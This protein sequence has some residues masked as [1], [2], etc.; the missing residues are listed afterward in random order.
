MLESSSVPISCCVES[1]PK[2]L[3]PK[4]TDL[5]STKG[6]WL[7]GVYCIHIPIIP[8]YPLTTYT[9]TVANKNLWG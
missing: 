5:E 9:D 6:T 8:I 7:G 3:K 4:F 1:V 2:N